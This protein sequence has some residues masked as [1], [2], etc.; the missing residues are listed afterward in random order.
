VAGFADRLT[1]ESYLN[2][3]KF[4]QAEFVT[5]SIRRTGPTTGE[6]TGNLTLLGQTHPITVQA[7][8][9]GIGANA[10]GVSTIGFQATGK[11]KRS[12]FGL[13]ILPGIIG[14]DIEL[15]IDADFNHQS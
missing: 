15:L 5:T 4:P 6:I 10:R 1:G 2:S 13:T 11:F 7:Q 8:L 3:D 14:D 12:D 9:V